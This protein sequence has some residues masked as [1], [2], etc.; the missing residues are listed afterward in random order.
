MTTAARA[1]LRPTALVLAGAAGGAALAAALAL[2]PAGQDRGAARPGHGSA[3][4]VEADTKAAMEAL[5][6]LVGRWDIEGQALDES[7]AVV[8]SFTG[9]AHY[10]FTLSDNFLMG[11]TTLLNGGY[12]LDQVDYI[13]F[14]PGLGKYTHV[15]LTELDKSMIYQ[16]GEWI[17]GGDG[18]VFAMA[19][20][21]DSPDGTPRTIGLQY[22]FA[23]KDVDVT[24]T[25]Q[26]GVAVPRTVRM[27]LTP[28][29]HP[30]APT[31]PGGMPTGG[32]VRVVQQQGDPAKMRAE[33]QQAMA[34]MTAQRQAVQSYFNQVSGSIDG[35]AGSPAPDTSSLFG[36]P[37]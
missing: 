1:A 21:L 9:N 5:D 24:M 14:S 26:Q 25:M 36:G 12:V 13:G 10:S 32:N 23:G 27:R 15:M 28:S 6:R 20:P 7:G 3:A 8:G 18:L 29:K 31:G 16:H 22:V 35:S 11:E 17:A 30:A 4:E 37:R 2:A 34:Q 33:M 19:A